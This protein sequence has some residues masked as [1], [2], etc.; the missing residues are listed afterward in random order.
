MFYPKL[1]QRA[2]SF[3]SCYL[4]ID[5]FYELKVKVNMKIKKSLLLSFIFLF[6]FSSPAFAEIDLD[7]QTM[8]ASKAATRAGNGDRGPALAVL[9]S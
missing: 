9:K 3:Y 4:R 8:N 2:S 6:S 5:P 7:I 1:T